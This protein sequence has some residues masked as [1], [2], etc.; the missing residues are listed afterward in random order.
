[1]FHELEQIN[2]RP[3]PFEFYTAAE[4]WTDEHISK[5]MLAFHLNPENDF[6]SRGKEFIDRSVAWIESHFGIGPSTHVADF[7]CGPGLYTARL[8]RLGAKVTGIDFSK[9]S[10]DYA[11]NKAAEEDLAV[12]YVIQDYFDFETEDRFDLI[13]MIQCDFCALSPAQR[14]KILSKF[15]GLLKPGGAVLLD[16]YSLVA[17]EQRENAVSYGPDLFDGFW[18]H[19]KYYGFTNTFRYEEE[20]VVLDK[21]TLVEEERIWSVYNWFQH[22]NQDQVKKEFEEAGLPIEAF[23]ADVAGSPFDPE[24]SEFAVVGRKA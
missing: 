17:F 20:K 14:K 10:I 12:Q 16:V 5:K 7:G 22:F 24:A 18:S 11:R 2:E 4:L 8:A 13:M 9:R 21:Y 1:M 15:H 23:F 19:A 3:E 6:C